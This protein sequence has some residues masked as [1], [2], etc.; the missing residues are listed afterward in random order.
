[1]QNQLNIRGKKEAAL[2]QIK[3]QYSQKF[4]PEEEIFK[5]IHAGDR[6]FIGSGCGEPQYLI[7]ALVNYVESNPKAFFD[8]EILQ[9]WTLGVAPYAGY[10]FRR[11]FR[12]NSFFIE[13]NAR[14]VVN[15]GMADYTPVF[16]SG[17]PDLFYRKL[18]PVDVALIQTS[19]PDE[20]GY[21]SLGISVDIVKAA[22]ENAALVIAQVNAHMPRVH[23]DTFIHVQDINFLVRHDEPLLEYEIQVQNEVAEKIGHHVAQLIEDGDTIQVGY[24][25]IPNAVLKS[26]GSKKHLGV[27]TELLNDGIVG[28]IKKGVIDN[29]RKNIDRGKT[30][31]T[32]CMGK[33][34][35]YEFL[36][37]NPSIEFR[38]IDYTNNPAIIARNKNMVAINSALEIDLTGQA[39][40]ESLGKKLMA[41]IGGQADFMRGAVLAQGGKTILALPSTAKGGQASRIVP[42][43]QEGAGVTLTR[44]DIHY[45]ITEYGIAYLFGKNIR[46]RAMSLIAIA[47]PRFR[48]GLIAAAK[49]LSLIYPD[50]AFIP[51]R[52]G[53]YPS[54]L[55]T[56]RTAKNGLKFFL[57]PVKINDEPLLKEFIYSLSEE[58][59]YKRFISR[60]KDMPHEML[61]DLFVVIDYTKEMVILATLKE[62]EKETV[63]GVGQYVI[64]EGTRT[65]DI[66]L[67]VRDDYQNQG[68]GSEIVSYLA[69][70]A[71]KQGILGFTAEILPDNVQILRLVE[72]VGFDLKKTFSAG[73]YMLEVGFREKQ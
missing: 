72:K 14:E 50:Q 65:A 38:T 51:G 53:E 21:L 26:L 4:R 68:V 54:K 62:E 49:E 13:K 29:S 6:I 73:V 40:A 52:A 71:R 56:Y 67:V 3:R 33:R 22:V 12:L 43:L 24:G 17:V 27:H 32:F 55:E 5:H 28:L 37:D 44:G 9:I 8:A 64:N 30:I 60:R 61:Q 66:S 20:H 25:N 41:G 16:A 70:L 69:Y 36:H 11:N 34:E 47:H 15:R 2:E 45:V 18:V 63:I 10:K 58:T 23:G 42:L 57:R 46:E 48:P 31:A 59:M 7:R 19:L 35:T 39:T 1:M